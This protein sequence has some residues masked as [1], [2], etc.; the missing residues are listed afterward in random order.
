MD[1]PEYERNALILIA[2][3][4]TLLFQTDLLKRCDPDILIKHD[5]IRKIKHNALMVM[6]LYHRFS[7]SLK[8]QVETRMTFSTYSLWLLLR[9]S[10]NDTSLLVN[11]LDRYRQTLDR[12]VFFEKVM[13]L[14]TNTCDLHKRVSLQLYGSDNIVEREM[15]LLNDIENFLKQID[16]CHC[17]VSTSAALTALR[18]IDNFL[19]QT[20]GTGTVAPPETYDPTQ[21]CATC[22]EELS[23]TAN[24]GET[25]Y[26]RLETKVCDHLVTQVDAHISFDDIRRHL[27]YLNGIEKSS[28]TR[29]LTLIDN[30][31][32]T[33]TTENAHHNNES[34]TTQRVLDRYDVFTEAPHQIYHL[35]ELQYWLAS[36]KRGRIHKANKSTAVKESNTSILQRFDSDLSKL[37]EQERHIE[38]TMRRVERIA[39]GNEFT[40]FHRILLTAKDDVAGRLLLGSPSV[41]PDA[42][43]DTLIG[44]CYTHHM[45]MG[46]FK[47]LQTPDTADEET[48]TR[49]LES[50]REQPSDIA[51]ENTNSNQNWLAVRETVNEQSIESDQ[52]DVSEMRRIAERD[53]ETRRD[54]YA[55]R[56]SARSFANLDRCVATQR[57]ELEKLMRINVFGDMLPNM[58]V[59]TINGFLARK[60]FLRACE[61][62]A[63]RTL[64]RLSPDDMAAYNWHHYVRSAVARH[65]LDKAILPSLSS[66]FYSCI[67]GPLFRH[68]VHNFPQPANT[69]LYFSVENVG[70]LPHLKEEL[71]NFMHD[72]SP[73]S[74]MI[75]GFR[76]FYDFVET[77]ITETYRTAC[78]YIREAVFATTIFDATFHCGE[79]QLMRADSIDVD[80]DGPRVSDGLYLTFDSEQPLIALW[81]TTEDKR[82]GPETV[83]V[84]EKDLYSALYSIL[85]KHV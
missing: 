81:G 3:L 48:L 77:N 32:S 37:L 83:A 40:H 11:E 23:M 75:S 43:I 64:T 15:C 26:R 54:R 74:W 44:A 25:I 60:E 12:R 46:I 28:L 76:H 30:A 7:A 61:T 9:R 1:I 20:I 58:Y 41:A 59:N 47:R 4:Q 2:Q 35:S 65:Q 5:T 42:A 80:V 17:I 57:S 51:S 34:S 45:S 56:L 38:H 14:D 49:L 18:D 27:P 19:L 6:Y 66:K 85:Q 84:I 70:L 16:Y 55:E 79:V 39:F 50:I 78:R 36:G 10:K 82:F 52:C 69:S 22:F 24:C 29:A 21:P 13:N 33:V 67:T 73:V 8:E 62:L 68:H 72:L 71:A 31:T 63:S 53:M